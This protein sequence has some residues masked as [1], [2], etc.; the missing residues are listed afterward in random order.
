MAKVTEEGTASSTF[1][2]FPISN[3]GKTGSATFQNNQHDFGREAFGVYAGFAPLENPKIAVC[4]VVYD[5]AHGGYVAPVA[6]AIYETYFKND[7]L[8]QNPSYQFM[9]PISK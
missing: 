8:A 7:I 5:G 6:K 1:N 3:G 9:Y 4:I 2:G